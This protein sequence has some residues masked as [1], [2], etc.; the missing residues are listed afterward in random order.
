MSLGQMARAAEYTTQDY[1]KAV[2]NCAQ[3]RDYACEEKNYRQ[4]LRLHPNDTTYLFNLGRVMA[5]QDRHKDAIVQFERAIE[6]GE[7]AWNLFGYY[8]TSLAEV[9]RTDEAIDWSY[10]T[11]SVMPK[12]YDIRSNLVKYL[13]LK[14]RYYEALSVIDEFDVPAHAKGDPQYF[15][16]QRIAIESTL[17]RLGLVSPAEEKSLRLPRADRF[18]YVPVT[19]GNGK[20]M[21]FILDTG[22]STMMVSEEF[23]Q[24]SDAHYKFLKNVVIGNA[25]GHRST[26]RSIVLDSIFIGSF[27]LKNVQAVACQSCYLLLGQTA[28]SRFNIATSK[29]QGVEFATLSPR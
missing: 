1:L 28:I 27:E 7:G 11:L 22:A 15:G 24:R 17:D 5:I 19:T 12:L 14:K 6:L 26:A 13:V 8:S 20:P 9:G 23:L 18:Y 10:K 25:D 4:L 2:G 21:P 16:G 3:V 29:V